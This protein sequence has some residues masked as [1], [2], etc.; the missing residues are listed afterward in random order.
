MEEIVRLVSDFRSYLEN[1]KRF[2]AHTVRNYI[3]DIEQFVEFLRKVFPDGTDVQ[4]IDVVVLR[5]FLGYLHSK[6]LDKR[7]IMRK[8]KM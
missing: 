6:E 1:E 4:K 2:S 3:S 7:S 8:R 5:G